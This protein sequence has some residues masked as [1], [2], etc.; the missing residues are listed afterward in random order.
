MSQIWRVA[1]VILLIIGLI[2]FFSGIGMQETQTATT[3][4]E[5]DYGWGSSGCVETEVDNSGA[6][7]G[8][9]LT[10]LVFSV[11]GLGLVSGAKSDEQAT[12]VE[13]KLMDKQC[14]QCD[15]LLVWTGQDERPNKP[16]AICPS[17]K[18]T[19]WREE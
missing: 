17:C 8:S 7:Y 1:G 16:K 3:C 13:N 14:P 9:I 5:T 15:S 10:G 18:D 4:Y 12:P 19:I 2:S 11:I 6:K